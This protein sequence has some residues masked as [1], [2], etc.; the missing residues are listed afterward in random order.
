MKKFAALLLVLAMAAVANATNP[1]SL[2]YTDQGTIIGP[3]TD[4]CTDYT[5]YVNHDGTFEN[6]YAWQYG[7]T[8]APYYGSFGE[9]YQGLGPGVV[10]CGAFWFS[11]MAGYYIGQ[12]FDAYVWDGALAP[13]IV[14]GV[15]TGNTPTSVP[16][17]PT[18]AQNNVTMNIAVA[19]DFTIGYW[20]NWPGAGCG[21]FC[22]ADL[23]GFGGI[24]WTYIA[25]GIGYP[26]G[27]NDPSI[28]WGPTMSMFCGAFF[29][30][31]TPAETQSWGSIKALFE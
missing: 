15:I 18:A 16:N 26:T 29:E 20:G 23:D 2:G 7:G 5:L 28:I 8:I 14:D 12:T 10:R 9:G 22:C 11:T 13:G 1:V 25:P 19:G 24:P 3:G 4:T 6:G 31:G 30:P 21:W 17:W 27:W